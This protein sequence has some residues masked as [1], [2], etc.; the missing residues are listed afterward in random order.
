[1]IK[2]SYLKIL[3]C[4]SC[5]CSTVVSETVEVSS[6][7]KA[8]VIRQHTNGERWESREFLCGY[9]AAWSPNFS[10]AREKAECRHSEAFIK[11]QAESEKLREKIRKLETELR[12][13]NAGGS[14][15]S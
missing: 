11:R 1:M 5:G 4:P 6:M 9:K 14:Y 3:K 12:N 10:S 8:R 13:L 7:S 2:F 15:T